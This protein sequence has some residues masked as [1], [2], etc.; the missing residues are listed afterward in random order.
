M[1][2]FIDGLRS[3]K[4]KTGRYKSDSSLSNY[5]LQFCLNNILCISVIVGAYNLLKLYIFIFINRSLMLFRSINNIFFSWVV[6]L[7]RSTWN[8]LFGL[9]SCYA[10]IIYY[11][12]SGT[13]QAQ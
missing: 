4:P 10:Y 12:F 8:Y 5:Y 1:V 7:L 9:Y 11:K 2:L 13:Y 3:Q 6:F